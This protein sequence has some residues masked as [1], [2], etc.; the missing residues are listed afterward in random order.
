MSKS[1]IIRI[2][3]A[4]LVIFVA[5]AVTGAFLGARLQMEKQ[6]KRA[7]IDQ[8]P[9]NVMEMLETRLSLSAE[10]SKKIEPDVKEACSELHEVYDASSKRVG[11]ILG[12][13]YGRISKDLSKEQSAILAKMENELREEAEKM[14]RESNEN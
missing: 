13:Y 1:L 3:L 9:D 8:L 2:G 11:Q 7:E 14:S 4:V 5:G 12:K 10:Q 6:T